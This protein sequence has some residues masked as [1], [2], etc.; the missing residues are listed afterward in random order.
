[1][2]LSHAHDVRVASG[3]YALAEPAMTLLAL[4][5]DVMATGGGAGRGGAQGCA[6]S[7]GRRLEVA[8]SP[9]TVSVGGISQGDADGRRLR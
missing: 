5:Y 7:A 3:P 6:S 1:M 9:S 4:Q 2:S 8:S